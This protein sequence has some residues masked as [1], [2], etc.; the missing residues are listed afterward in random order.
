[1]SV[2]TFFGHRDCPSSIKP[3]LR[4]TLCELIEKDG[5][6]SFYV[7]NHGKF[8][9]LVLSVLRE[10]KNDYPH[11]R[12]AVVLAYLP[13]ERDAFAKDEPNTLFPEGIENAPPRFAISYRNRWMLKQAAYVVTYVTHSWGR[14]ARLRSRQSG[15]G[16]S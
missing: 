4:Q 2:C 12:Y 5:V 1:M 9:S 3:L 6:E 7:G 14:A 15:R 13:G 8:D 10:L 16:R 11:I